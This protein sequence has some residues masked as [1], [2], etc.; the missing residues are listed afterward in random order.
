MFSGL[1]CGTVALGRRAGGG[2]SGA[3]P[4]TAQTRLPSDRSPGA[5]GRWWGGQDDERVRR[6]PAA[7][8]PHRSIASRTPA[9]S[10]VLV[11]C[12]SL[13]VRLIARSAAGCSFGNTQGSAS[14]GA[15]ITTSLVLGSRR[16]AS[17]TAH[18]SCFCCRRA[19]SPSA[20]APPP[21]SPTLGPFAPSDYASPRDSVQGSSSTMGSHS[22]RNCARLC[23]VSNTITR[24]KPRCSSTAQ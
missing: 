8:A 10:S 23:S 18:R 16:S 19:V 12:R 3:A 1:N 15:S 17:L 14:R 20:P 5:R 22:P 4:L 6:R 11:G 13:P 21:P 24:E 9:C 2:A 7:G